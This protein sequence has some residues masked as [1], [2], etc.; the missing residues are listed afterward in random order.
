MIRTQNHLVR[1]WTLNHLTKLAKWLACVVSTALIYKEFLLYVLI[2]S[3]TRFWENPHSADIPPVSSRE[4]LDI[5]A[6]ITFAEDRF[7]TA[8]DFQEHL[9][10]ITADLIT[11]TEEIRNRKLHFCAVLQLTVWGFRNHQNITKVKGNIL[12]EVDATTEGYLTGSVTQRCFAKKCSETFGKT[13]RKTPV[14]MSILKLQSYNFIKKESLAKIISCEFY[15]IYQNRFFTKALWKAWN[16]LILTGRLK[17]EMFISLLF[18][19]SFSSRNFLSPT[20]LL[21]ACSI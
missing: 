16:I 6:I 15:E 9:E 17:I 8:S 20:L 2:I 12:A 10:F 13:H 18:F 3:R 14:Q 4:F 7:A 5:Q 11:F 21:K 1:K 19:E